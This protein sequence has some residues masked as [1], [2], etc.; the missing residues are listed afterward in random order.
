MTGSCSKPAFAVRGGGIEEDG[1]SVEE[2]D[3]DSSEARMHNSQLSTKE[4]MTFR[5]T[6][7]F[8]LIPKESMIFEI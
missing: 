5:C 1:A 3:L 2:N 4:R 6:C 8:F 7:H